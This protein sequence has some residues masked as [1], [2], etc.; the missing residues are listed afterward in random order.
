MDMMSKGWGICITCMHRSDCV[1]FQ[2][3]LR[4]ERP[5][6]H[7]SEYDHG[8]ADQYGNPHREEPAPKQAVQSTHDSGAETRRG[9][10]INCANR[11]FCMLPIAA[12]GTWHCEEYA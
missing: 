7:C 2:N 10:C 5:V 4:A 11:S 12:G 1:S 3:G 8:M 9:I 6:W